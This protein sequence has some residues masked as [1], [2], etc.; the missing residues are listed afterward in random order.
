MKYPVSRLS[1]QLNSKKTGGLFGGMTRSLSDDPNVNWT[2][3][4]YTTE[5]L[6]IAN[7]YINNNI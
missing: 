6:L 5:Y 4:N 2:D 1:M 7:V 3:E